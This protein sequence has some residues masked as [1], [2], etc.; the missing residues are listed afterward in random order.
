MDV[1]ALSRTTRL[2]IGRGVA[3][4]FIMANYWVKY[5]SDDRL[6]FISSGGGRGSSLFVDRGISIIWANEQHS[7]GEN[8]WENDQRKNDKGK[9][10][11]SHS[12]KHKTF[13]FAL[14]SINR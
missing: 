14:A 13:N 2:Y 6:Y 3:G 11:A 5:V 8:H 7:L 10:I 4:S 9:I 12:C 1:C